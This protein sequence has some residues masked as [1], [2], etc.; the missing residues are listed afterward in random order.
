MALAWGLL[1]KGKSRMDG[2][3]PLKVYKT[4]GTTQIDNLKNIVL[5][6][7][8]SMGLVKMTWF[9]KVHPHVVKGYLWTSSSWVTNSDA[10]C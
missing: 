6:R 1:S 4:L 7:D 8:I 9:D 5:D 3:C 2:R 10:M